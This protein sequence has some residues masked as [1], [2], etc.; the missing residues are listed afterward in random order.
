MNTLSTMKKA[1]FTFILVCLCTIAYGQI[2]T[3]LLNCGSDPLRYIEKNYQ[4]NAAAYIGKTIGFWADQSELQLNSCKYLC[5]NHSPYVTNKNL[6]GK[7]DK[8][9]LD[10][11]YIEGVNDYIYYIYI[12]DSTPLSYKD[13]VNLY[14][15]YEDY[16]EPKFYNFYKNAKIKEI[17]IGKEINGVY[18]N[19]YRRPTSITVPVGEPE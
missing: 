14:G 17:S 11:N 1:I 2:Y 5:S 13:A 18:R 8:I 10:V 7:V 12:D 3:T 15:D 4:D 19:E 16:W 9:R 6:L